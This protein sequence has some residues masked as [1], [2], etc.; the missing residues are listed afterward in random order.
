MKIH[1]LTRLLVL[2]LIV[3]GCSV[4]VEQPTAQALTAALPTA[5]PQLLEV[6]PLPIIIPT[7]TTEQATEAP[8]T[9][10]PVQIPVTWA[11]LNLT[12]KLVYTAV[13]NSMTTIN[14][15]VLDLI[16]GQVVTIFQIPS[17]GWADA[18]VVSPDVKTLILSYLPPTN[19]SYGGQAS[20]YS[21]PAD[22]SGPLRILITPPTGTDQ[23]SQPVW[24][25]D[26]R[27]VYFAHID[28]Q[29]MTTYEIMRMAYP[30]GKPEK[31]IEHAYWPRVSNDGTQF[32]Y[33]A[34]DPQSGV[35]SLFIANGDGTDPHQISLTGL[36][37]P[38]VIDTPMFSS[39]NQTI[40]FSS[41]DATRSF[42]P[43]WVD[44]I[45]G[46]ISVSADGSLPSD[47]WS[48]PIT[49]GIAHQLTH[50]QALALYGSFSPDQQY[51][52]S[53]SANGI[54]VMKPNGTEVTMI[55]NEVGG[56]V[57]TVNW[58]P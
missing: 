49:G 45:F 57:G 1:F 9:P 32:I 52:A 35:N 26:S 7:A 17:G 55:V 4:T 48:V 21:L 29:S 5:T 23:Y 10:A 36:P 42:A 22:G 28:L 2:T 37:V 34:L 11:N 18:A 41:P 24:S 50:I 56:I 58:I 6:S 19:A 40:L 8:P 47:W 20:L 14:V 16:T 53:Y 31:L 33:V 27:Y 46:V 54:F 44:R 39:D 51:I 12:G 13:D 43:S 15:Q 3:S 38:S 25:P 30:D